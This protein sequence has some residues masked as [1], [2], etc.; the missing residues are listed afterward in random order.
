MSRVYTSKDWIAAVIAFVVVVGVFAWMQIGGRK[1][2]EERVEASAS[3]RCRQWI[4]ESAKNPSSAR[5]PGPSRV[6]TF[7]DRVVVTWVI[8]DGLTLMNGFGSNVDT[9]A[10]CTMSKDGV[11][12]K[13]LVIDGQIVKRSRS[14]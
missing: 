2:P 8:G 12:L 5:V 14:E 10:R 4:K 6:H 13:E 7:S 9:A 11:F 3:D 1:S